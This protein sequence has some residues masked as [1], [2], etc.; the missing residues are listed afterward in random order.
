MNTRLSTSGTQPSPYSQP[1]IT[2]P[3]PAR[4]CNRTV[5]ALPTVLPQSGCHQPYGPISLSKDFPGSKYLPYICTLF[6]FMETLPQNQHDALQSFAING[7]TAHILL[8][9]LSMAPAWLTP[10]LVR[11]VMVD[12]GEH[13]TH[14]PS[15]WTQLR[16]GNDAMYNCE[17][18]RGLDIALSGIRELGWHAREL[19][20]FL[21]TWRHIIAVKAG[22]FESNKMSERRALKESVNGFLTTPLAKEGPYGYGL[23]RARKLKYDGVHFKDAPDTTAKISIP[24]SVKGV[25]S[26]SGQVWGYTGTHCIPLTQYLFT[27]KKHMPDLKFRFRESEECKKVFSLKGCYLG[28]ESAT[29]VHTQNAQ[30][31][32]AMAHIEHLVNK[33]LAGDTSVLPHIHWWYVQLAPVFRGPG[34]VAEMLVK[35]LACHNGYRLPFWKKGLAPSVEVL[36]QPDENKFCRDYPNLFSTSPLSHTPPLRPYLTEEQ[37]KKR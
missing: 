7:K 1:H 16:Y 30:I 4:A 6:S 14:P 18:Q 26:R 15:G 27:T 36:L 9:K 3:P 2:V 22:S 35:T 13:L 8:S 23:A 12:H 5:A 10:L 25:I 34:G 21:E 20:L 29:L 17:F 32:S 33:A 19:I 24:Q 28:R 37:D 11:K 31:P